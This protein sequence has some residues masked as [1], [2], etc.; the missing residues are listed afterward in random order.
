MFHKEEQ[1]HKKGSSFLF[2][3]FLCLSSVLRGVVSLG[4]FKCCFEEGVVQDALSFRKNG[5]KEKKT[6][7]V[8]CVSEEFQARRTMVRF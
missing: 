7:V 4:F 5:S 3:S 8:F 2:F 1:H 6:L